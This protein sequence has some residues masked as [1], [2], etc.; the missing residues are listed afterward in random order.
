MRPVSAATSATP[1]RRIA[2]SLLRHCPRCGSRGIFRTYLRLRERCPSCE[3]EFAAEEG[4]FLGV[5]VLNFAV[6]EGL[7]FLTLIGYIFAMAATGG[8]VPLLP[9]FA[10]GLVVALGGPLVFYP[11]AAST[12]AAVE[13]IMDP[14]RAISRPP[15]A[16]G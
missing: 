7:L 2:R 6:S 9:V 8:D 15:G 12:W 4:F 3:Y 10:V 5:W 11:F 1:L 13:L 16:A 14:S